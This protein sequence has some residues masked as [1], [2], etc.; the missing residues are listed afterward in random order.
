LSG[1]QFIKYGGAKVE[2]LVIF[3]IAATLW[4]MVLLDN[5]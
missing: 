5:R 1:G 4:A 2:F 3:A